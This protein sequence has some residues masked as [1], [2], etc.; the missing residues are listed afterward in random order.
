MRGNDKG[1]TVG[2]L[3]MAISALIIASLIWSAFKGKNES[4]NF[5]HNDLNISQVIG[6]KY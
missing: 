1:L 4:T 5:H 6:I 2:E 3:T